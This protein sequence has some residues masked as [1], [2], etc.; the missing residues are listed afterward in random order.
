MIHYLNWGSP[1]WKMVSPS[2]LNFTEN[3]FK[4][5]FLP[6]LKH[7]QML[8]GLLTF[9]TRNTKR[10]WIRNLLNIIVLFVSFN[11]FP[12]REKN[13][14][15]AGGSY[16]LPSSSSCQNLQQNLISNLTPFLF[17]YFSHLGDNSTLTV[18]IIMLIWSIEYWGKIEFVWS[19]RA[20]RN[21]SN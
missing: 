7:F 20:G 17:K 6:Q 5:I 11:V 10:I 15:T 4:K 19:K 18:S 2:L 21:D 9:S 12:W 3:L 14:Q 1:S 13:H 16:F 8:T